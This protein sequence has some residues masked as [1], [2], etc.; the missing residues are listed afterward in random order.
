MPVVIPAEFR[1]L[2]E[3]RPADDQL[4]HP[5][6]GDAW[7]ARLPRLVDDHLARWGLTVD[8]QPRFGENALVIPVVREEGPAALKLT[9]PH[10]EGRSEHLA[11][12]LW[13]GRGAVRLLA[14]DPGDFVLL[15]ERL[16]SSRELTGVPILEAP[17]EPTEAGNE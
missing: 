6:T 4:P 11:L 9:W 14:A 13:D 7:L 8:G 17:A 12:R 16:D 15:L 2:L 5:V 10:D 3:G 1:T